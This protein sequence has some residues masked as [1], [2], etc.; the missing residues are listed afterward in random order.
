MPR[1]MLMIVSE[2]PMA[3]LLAACEPKL[4]VGEVHLIVS[5]EMQASGVGDRLADVLEKRKLACRWHS[6]SEPFQP[7]PTR[8]C[9]ARLLADRP[10]SWIVNLTGGTKPMAIGA[11]RAALDG[12]VRDIIYLDHDQGL[13]RWMD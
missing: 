5:G 8:N 12:G 7:E 3:N 9:A 4:D 1:R 2:Q 10:E 11:Y 6:V 13:L